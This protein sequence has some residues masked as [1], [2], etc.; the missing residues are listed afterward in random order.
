MEIE[1]E[2]SKEEY[3]DWRDSR[4]TKFVRGKLE[5]IKSANKD[6]VANGG[7]LKGDGP[8]TDFIVGYIQGL[9]EFLNTEYEEKPDY[10]H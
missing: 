7:T 8:S 10:G 4:V 1:N 3:I 5:E 2:I 6:F 9:N